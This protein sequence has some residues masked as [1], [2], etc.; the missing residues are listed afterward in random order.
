L[1]IVPLMSLQVASYD[2]RFGETD[3]VR[4]RYL[5]YVV[6]LVT[7]AAAAALVQRPPGGILVAAC[8]AVFV[9][10][11]PAYEFPVVEP[12]TVDSP[13]A[14][15]NERIVELAGSLSPGTFVAAAVLLLAAAFL[16]GK[17]LVRAPVLAVSVLGLMVAFGVVSGQGA[18]ARVLDSVGPSGRTVGTGP[19]SPADWVDGVLPDGETAAI[20]AYPLAGD[21]GPSAARWWDVEFWNVRVA[22]ALV[23]PGGSFS[24]T[25]FPVE[26][27]A[28]DWDSGALRM[29]AE[30]SF[31]VVASDDAR[32]RVAGPRRA[33]HD[34]LEL[35]SAERPYRADWATRGVDADGWL[36]AERP[37]VLR[38]YA[39]PATAATIASL[40]VVLKA[41]ESAPATYTLT[42]G[43]DA[44]TATVEPTA[45][46]VEH[47]DVCVPAGGHVDLALATEPA[48]RLPEVAVGPS[49]TGTRVVGIRLERVVLQ[50]GGPCTA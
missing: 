41:P 42:N 10:F 46:A 28:V 5:F 48:T 23:G 36:R 20:L 24:Y 6:P 26:Q 38:V 34:G 43:G 47:L 2:L 13:V 27:T 21:W 4:D 12:F 35:V 50:R 18:F 49:P 29:S 16:A 44:R 40:D 7:A 37:A 1:V 32:F 39:G 25:P 45:A 17:R 9:L 3:L 14:L 31:L 11:V 19:P 30:T 8:T 22:E 15:L 33:G